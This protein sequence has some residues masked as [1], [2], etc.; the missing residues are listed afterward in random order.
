AW[1]VCP[2]TSERC[3]RRFRGSCAGR[4]SELYSDEGCP[5][6]PSFPRKRE[7]MLSVSG[8]DDDESD[9]QQMDS[10]FRGNDDSLFRGN[11]D[12]L[13]RG[14]DDSLFRGN[15]DSLAASGIVMTLAKLDL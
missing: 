1:G 8:C 14:N 5:K 10:R 6:E 7:S 15:D 4:K 2:V 11:D 13:F 12:S 9:R 3:C